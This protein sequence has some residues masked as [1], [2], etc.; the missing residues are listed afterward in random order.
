MA[1]LII[2]VQNTLSYRAGEN[3]NPINHGDMTTGSTPLQMGPRGCTQLAGQGEQG[4][5][6]G[7]VGGFRTWAFCSR[8]EGRA[9]SRGLSHRENHWIPQLLPQL[10][11]P[12]LQAGVSGKGAEF[13]VINSLRA[14]WP[15]LSSRAFFL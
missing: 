13:W 15:S 10:T 5:A 7:D 4:E 9:P 8:E 6:I 3:D 14:A 2:S 12:E 11:K 1:S